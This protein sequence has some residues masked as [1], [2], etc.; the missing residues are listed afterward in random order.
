MTK[1]G[2]QNTPTTFEKVEQAIEDFVS[3]PISDASS[4]G[5][6]SETVEEVKTAVG[7][8]ERPKAKDSP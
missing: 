6:T 8:A 5:P 3:V 2:T 7:E 4:E 1:P